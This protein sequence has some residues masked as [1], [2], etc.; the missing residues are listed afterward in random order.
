MSKKLQMVL[1]TKS[2]DDIH[3]ELI[4]RE[5]EKQRQ[6]QL[7]LLNKRQYILPMQLLKLMLTYLP[8]YYIVWL[9][10]GEMTIKRD[11]PLSI[12]S[13]NTPMRHYEAIPRSYF[14]E[15]DDLNYELYY[16][17]E[18]EE[19]EEYEQTYNP[20]KIKLKKKIKQTFSID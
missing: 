4:N 1:I 10:S 12:P 11:M 9:P 15:Y 2:N 17:S 6:A 18:Y 13:P 8:G 14:K 7:V 5:K 19:Y 16:E 3:Y 20:D